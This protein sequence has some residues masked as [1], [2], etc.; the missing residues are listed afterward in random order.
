[1]ELAGDA[2]AL[3]EHRFAGDPHPQG[4]GLLRDL[5]AQQRDPEQRH[6]DQTAEHGNHADQTAHGPQAGRLQHLQVR[7]LPQ[8]QHGALRPGAEAAVRR[9]F[10]QG[11]AGEP[12]AG[13][14]PQVLQGLGRRQFRTQRH[15]VGKQAQLHPL[16]GAEDVQQLRL[17]LDEFGVERAVEQVLHRRRH[18]LDRLPLRRHFAVQA[19]IDQAGAEALHVREA[20]HL[21]TLAGLQ[22]LGLDQA[23]R[24]RRGARRRR[25][26]RLAGPLRAGDRLGH[27][28]AHKQPAVVK[29]RQHAAA[30]AHAVPARLALGRIE[31]QQAGRGQG[32][33]GRRRRRR[34]AHLDLRPV[35]HAQVGKNELAAVVDAA[36]GQPRDDQ[37]GIDPGLQIRGRRRIDAHLQHLVAD[38]QV[39]QRP[40]FLG[41][42]QAAA[43]ALH[44]HALVVVAAA[45]Q[46]VVAGRRGRGRFA[47]ADDGEGLRLDAGEVEARRGDAGDLHHV[48]HL[49][50]VGVGFGAEKS[51]AAGV[52]EKHRAGRIDEADHAA[53]LH[54]QAVE[55]LVRRQGPHLGGLA[56]H[57]LGQA[58]NGQ[59]QPGGQQ[60]LH[61]CGTGGRPAGKCKPLL[62]QWRISAWTRH[63]GPA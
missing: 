35:G 26:H 17:H 49:Q 53:Q 37:F 1:M 42:R 15:A 4:A 8:Q 31:A 22:G 14:R 6:H 10:H 32:L 11:D 46:V 44:A 3:L 34:H 25:R 54:R 33:D 50:P 28:V 48:A 40:V 61:A 62:R 12:Q 51:A 60:R 56:Q 29:G 24:Q 7:R 41:R 27:E 2:L 20:D 9:R 38:R 18:G 19:R 16:G 58:G 45:A 55:R 30:D 5:A 47:L 52:L 63:L 13:T 43:D 59:Q 57:L 23:D 21:D 39:Q 36:G